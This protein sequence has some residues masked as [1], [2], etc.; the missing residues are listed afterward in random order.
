[1]SFRLVA[2]SLTLLPAM[3][4]PAD[5][6]AQQAQSLPLPSK[7]ACAP[8]AS[9]VSI[10]VRDAAGNPIAGTTVDMTRLRDGKSLGNATEMRAGRGEFALLESDALQ[11]IAAK[12][13][14]IRVRA[15]AGKRSATTV[16]VVGRDASGCR[17]TR[18][19]GSSVLTLK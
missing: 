8:V 10:L 7:A 13:D 18:L 5:L 3:T 19:S 4:T 12:G 2:L 11:W 6:P 15:R 16:I 1:M 17:I 14:R 9:L